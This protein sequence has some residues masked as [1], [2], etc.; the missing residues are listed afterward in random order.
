MRHLY[1]D[2][3]STLGSLAS[4]STACEYI[5]IYLFCLNFE[6][7]FS[8]TTHDLLLLWKFIKEER[9]EIEKGSRAQSK[10]AAKM[11]RV[12]SQK[13]ERETAESKHSLT[14]SEGKESET[15]ARA[16]IMKETHSCKPMDRWA[17]QS[18]SQ[19]GRGVPNHVLVMV[20]ITLL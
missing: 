6:T 18:W 5:S 14:C 19:V 9:S 4:N 15:Q 10:E 17:T 11:I 1:R 13:R 7:N 3:S 2:R 20:L 16:S 8:F 12:K